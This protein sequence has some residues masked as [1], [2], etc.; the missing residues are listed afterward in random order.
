M[1]DEQNTDALSS[2]PRDPLVGTTIQ[3]RYR[4]VKKLGQGGMGAVYLAEHML[5]QK[6]V[7]IKCLHAGLASNA[8]V[9]R[10]FHNEAVSATAI[11]H[12][13]IVDVTDMGRFDDGTFFMALEF[14]DG[15]D[16][17]H[18]LDASG[19]QPLSK[20]A[21]I[22]MQICDALEA[23]SL[24]GIVHRDL[25]PE[26]IF[27]IER[28][29]DRDFVKVLDFG[30]SKFHDGIGGSTRTGELMGT[31]YYM[32]P[33]QIRGDRNLSHVADIYALGVIF[34]QA[35]TGDV[36]FDGNTLPELILK[37]A[38]QEAPRLDDKM[39]GMPQPIIDLV[40]GMLS[41]SAHERP[42]TFEAVAQVLSGYLE[43]G[44]RLAG[45]FGTHK[46][47]TETAVGGSADEPSA[48]G[49]VPER[50]RSAT[51]VGPR[52]PDTSAGGTPGA[53]GRTEVP[54]TDH[55]STTSPHSIT[56]YR[57]TPDSPA[58][59]PRTTSNH[60]LGFVVAAVAILGLGGWYLVDRASGPDESPGAAA[61][62]ENLV[63]VRISTL[64]FDADL[65][66]DGEP[67]SNPFNGAMEKDGKVHELIAKREGFIDKPQ[68]LRLN[69]EQ[70]VLI[71]MKSDAPS[72]PATSLSEV[73]DPP[74]TSSPQTKSP[75]RPQVAPRPQVVAAPTPAPAAAPSPA[76]TPAP[77][78]APAPASDL[79]AIK[80]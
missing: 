75:P 5:I 59:A 28:H 12:P 80:F 50:G 13:N 62:A 78:P 45:S 32:A 31:P 69:A 33:E 6:K 9:V 25:K 57:K 67:I 68:T 19:A 23:A 48:G 26:N 36:P 35:L 27:L 17:Q 37:I 18:D 66:L 3:D 77:A 24:K 70:T 60:Q 7:A 11:G 72:S 8:D 22:G 51:P 38:S 39:A 44:S 58:T 15:R 64:P 16:W 56:N 61:V 74:K 4:V 21:H 55:G 14:L 53:Y 73:K 54:R 30:I 1:S 42:Q 63:T 29:G 34:F 40:A 20:V 65:F 71:Q 10:R 47:F 46:G 41:K 52:G 79:K 49:I 76:Q 2:S 43:D